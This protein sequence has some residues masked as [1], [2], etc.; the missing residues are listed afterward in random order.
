MDIIK[1]KYLKTEFQ[2][3]QSLTTKSE[4][5]KHLKQAKTKFKAMSETEKETIREAFKYNLAT[6]NNKLQEID[7]EIKSYQKT[8]E[9]YPKNEEEMQ[10]LEM[11]LKK[12]GIGFSLR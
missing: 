4:K 12:M 2:Q 5:T 7:K 6:I 1:S 11:V 9:V 3:Y 8:I 10:L